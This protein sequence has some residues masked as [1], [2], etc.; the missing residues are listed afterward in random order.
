[1]RYKVQP[2][3]PTPWATPYPQLFRWTIDVVNSIKI[4]FS[5][6]FLMSS[7]KFNGRFRGE[8]ATKPTSA[9]RAKRT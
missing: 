7:L 3:F 8:A 6:N 5:S 9:Y 1:M 4:Q 2:T